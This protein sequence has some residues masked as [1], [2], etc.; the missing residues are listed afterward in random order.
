[1]D[2]DGDGV[3]D[4]LLDDVKV[5]AIIADGANRK[6][7]GTDGGIIVLSPS[8]NE[9]LFSFNTSNSP[10]F[11]NQITALGQDQER[12]I[13][14]IG[15]ANGLMAFR[16]EATRSNSFNAP[17]V[18]AFPNPVRPEYEGPIAIKGVAEDAIVKITDTQGKL[19]FETIA[20]GGQAIWDGTEWSGERVAS[21]VYLAWIT[22]RGDFVR[23]SDAVIKIVVV[24]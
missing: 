12:G 4:F 21:G 6:W 20:F 1:V 16:T 18:F 3:G 19:L 15:T 24:R 10:L 13:I 8:G 5:N 14:Y 7:V 17:D 9:E 11:S 23:P 2:Q 22:G